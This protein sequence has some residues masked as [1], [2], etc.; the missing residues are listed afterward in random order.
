MSRSTRRDPPTTLGISSY[1]WD[2]GDGATGSG[3]AAAHVYRKGGSFTATLRVADTSGATDEATRRIEVTAVNHPP[4][5]VDDS[6]NAEGTGAIDALANDG[7]PDAD[8]LRL[9][10]SSKPAHGSASC[11][12]LGACLYTSDAAY[13]G[14]DAFT[15]TVRDPDGLEATAKVS[16]DVTTAPAPSS[17]IPRADQASTRQGTAV[18]V[19][20]LA[21][22][23]GTGLHLT[24]ATDPAHG[25]VACE[26]DG[27]CVYTPAAGYSGNDGFSYTVANADG[28]ERSA[29][30]GVA[31]APSAAGYGVKVG[32]AAAGAGKA[33]LVQGQG[34]A[35]ARR[36]R[37]RPRGSATRR[38]PR[39]PARR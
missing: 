24:H 19:H 8:T 37:P 18:T 10:S 26:A 12:A 39:S 25:A 35:G 22:D 20:V 9:V 33:G 38:S 21:N 2:F 34:R 1:E 15:Y 31:V 17:L 29:D 6:L 5:P 28:D 27:T 14:S 32:G 36:C 11:T 23:S 4:E 30:V 13:Q 3:V 16:V 7:D